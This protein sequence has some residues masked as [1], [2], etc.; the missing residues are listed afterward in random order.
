MPKRYKVLVTGSNGML[1]VDLCAELDKAFDVYGAD[2]VRGDGVRHFS[3]CD[4][5]DK[6]SVTVVIEKIKPDIVVHTAA[7]TD[8]DG[9]E[10][11]KDKAYNVN[12]AGAEN[13]AKACAAAGATMIHISTDFVFDGTKKSGPY[14]ED[15]EA[16]PLS[17]YGD[18]K[19]KG[20]EAVIEG[21][22]NYFILRT[23]WL[24]GKHGKNF[25]ETIITKA[26]GEDVLQV[27]ND[28]V[29]SPTYTKDLAG[30]IRVVID[31]ISSQLTAHSSQGCGIYHVS[32]SG[33]VSWYEYAKEVLK[34]TGSET[35][36]VPISSEKLNRPAK[37]PAMSVLDNSKFT[38]FTGHKMRN[39]KDALKEYILEGR[40]K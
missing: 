28:Q 17:I 9:C 7:M 40:G 25:V 22:K 14:R 34:L 37:R 30:A 21:V 1:G 4:I 6:K 20:E 2:I 33:S 15:D 36:V 3:Q 18:S 8:V 13:V 38:R 35:E 31:K 27:V 16:L 23:S 29:G 12:T 5:T 32:N 24:Y 26:S 11:D 10:R 39:W 19:F